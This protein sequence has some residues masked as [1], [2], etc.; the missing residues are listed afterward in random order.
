VN[1][2]DSTADYLT[3]AEAGRALGLTSMRVRQ[4]V[5]EGRLA[6]IRTPLGRLIERQSVEALR[7]KRAAGRA[8]A[9]AA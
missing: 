9:G 6:A 8:G 2:A 5:A 4:L 3:P 7:R 1:G